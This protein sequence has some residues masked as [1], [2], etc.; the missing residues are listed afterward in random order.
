MQGK[1]E[2]KGDTGVYGR[3]VLRAAGSS[4]I[5]AVL[6]PCSSSTQLKAAYPPLTGGRGERSGE[7]PVPISTSYEYKNCKH[8]EAQQYFKATE[9]QSHFIAVRISNSR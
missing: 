6:Q 1:K 3:N 2:R 5:S 7:S 9:T 8:R 4:R